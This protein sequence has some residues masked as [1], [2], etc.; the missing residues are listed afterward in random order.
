MMELVI[1]FEVEIGRFLQEE[2]ERKSFADFWISPRVVLPTVAAAAAQDLQQLGLLVGWQCQRRSIWD[3]DLSA[4]QEL[5]PLF[6]VFL[7]ATSG[8][9]KK[10]GEPG[11]EQMPN[12]AITRAGDKYFLFLHDKDFIILYKWW[13]GHKAQHL[14]LLDP[15]SR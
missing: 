4:E 11:R 12:S 7:I 8:E 10:E 1:L 5:I 14:M 13:R 6:A 15:Y 2:E 3:G 9:S